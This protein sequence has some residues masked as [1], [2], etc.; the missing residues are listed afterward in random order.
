MQQSK[1]IDFNTSFSTRI[2]HLQNKNAKLIAK[3]SKADEAAWEECETWQQLIE[4]IKSSEERLCIAYNEIERLKKDKIVLSAR[5]KRLSRRQSRLEKGMRV[6]LLAFQRC[7]IVA[8]MW[9]RCRHA[10]GKLKTSTG[11]KYNSHN[12]KE[13]L[14]PFAS[15]VSS[16]LFLRLLIGLLPPPQTRKGSFRERYSCSLAEASKGCQCQLEAVSLV[17]RQ[18][19]GR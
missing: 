1:V 17:G 19:G 2:R 3:L 9:H 12:S 6:A 16:G 10:L 7:G 13:W 8:E 14:D 5:A 11:E 15:G 18:C 4:K